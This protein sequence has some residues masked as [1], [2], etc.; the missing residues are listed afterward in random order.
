MPPI[1]IFFAYNYF[2]DY[3]NE[4]LIKNYISRLTLD[5][6]IAFS[7]KN[8][9]LLDSDEV[10]IVMNYIKNDWHT[11]IYGNPRPIL[12]D[13][14][15]KFDVCRYKKIENLYIEFKEKYKNYL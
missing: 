13:L 14:K 2:G 4:F 10:N 12:D 1:F 6:V 11:I 7:K 8:G 9:I 3:M 5:D 15:E